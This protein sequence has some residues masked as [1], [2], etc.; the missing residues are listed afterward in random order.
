[1]CLLDGKALVFGTEDFVKK[2]ADIHKG[3]AEAGAKASPLMARARDLGDRT[4]WIV[5]DVKIPPIPE[6]QAGMLGMALPGFDPAKL[7]GVTV[8]GK[9]TEEAFNL[10]IILGCEDE[11]SAAGTVTGFKQGV[12]WI[13]G[14][15]NMFT[16][17][18][19]ESGKALG[20]LIR[21]IKIIPGDTSATIDLTITA[22]LAEKLKAAGQ[23]MA[24]PMMMMMQGAGGADGMIE[25]DDGEEPIDWGEEE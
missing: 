10:R 9:V 18:D 22:E 16:Q 3:D 17:Q 25:M 19:P 14:M 13:N 23:K 1:M 12:N 4:F 8:A 2:V 24:G 20:E 6:D 11:D 15:A 5:A 7:N 21:A